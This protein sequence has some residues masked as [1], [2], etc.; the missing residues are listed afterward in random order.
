MTEARAL[1]SAHPR[2]LDELGNDGRVD[3]V[4]AAMD[5]N[6]PESLRFLAGI[7]VKLD[8][9]KGNFNTALHAAAMAGKLDLVQ[10]LVELGADP[11]VREPRFNATPL[12]WAVHG[13]Q[14]RVIEY[15]LPFATRIFDAVQADS[16]ERLQ[17]LLQD[18]PTRARA[19][20][21]QGAPVSFYLHS[22]LTHLDEIVRL[23]LAHGADINERSKGG[24]TCLDWA[25][26]RYSP[27]F[28]ERLRGHGA[29]MAQELDAGSQAR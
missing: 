6:Q 29:K 16:V 27:D 13:Q 25:S 3:L 28:V 7:G 26:S 12:G 19:L 9:M 4:F 23:L 8:A 5:A 17:Q 11:N 14:V 15:L 20:D 1:V 24:K 22:G 21:E 10:L 18:D 2:L